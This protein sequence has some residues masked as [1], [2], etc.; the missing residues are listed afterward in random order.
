MEMDEPTRI[1]KVLKTVYQMLR[2][3]GYGVSDSL[4]QMTKEQF[5]DTDYAQKKFE[6]FSFRKDLNQGEQISV[7]YVR[8][9]KISKSTLKDKLEQIMKTGDQ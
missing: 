8:D 7:F 3:R 9:D 5:L 4:L 1:F 6:Y 2:D